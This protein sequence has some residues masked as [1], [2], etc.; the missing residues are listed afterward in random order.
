ME[1]HIEEIIPKSNKACFAIRP[2]RPYLSYEVVSI[3]CFAYFHSIMSY[4]IIFW[5]NWS[6]NNSI[7][8]IQTRT[9][10]GNV[11]QAVEHL[12]TNYLKHYRFWPL[13]LSILILI[14]VCC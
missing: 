1:Y 6:Q 5:G 3:M 13:S 9:I 11:I 8:K 2:V 7:F 10:K 14:N 12:V 4:G